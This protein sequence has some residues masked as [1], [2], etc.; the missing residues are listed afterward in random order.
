MQSQIKRPFQGMIL[1]PEIEGWKPL[2]VITLEA[3]QDAVGGYV[4]AITVPYGTLWCIDEAPWSTIANMYV[5]LFPTVIKDHGMLFGTMVFTG[6]S[7]DNGNTRPLGEKWARAVVRK[8]AMHPS[9]ADDPALIMWVN[10]Y[11]RTHHHGG[12]K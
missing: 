1:T 7:D 5:F 12:V 2:P 9:V 3:L 10:Q 4:T 8:V 11:Y 6:E